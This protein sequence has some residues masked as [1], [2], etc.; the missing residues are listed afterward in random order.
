MA[1]LTH[2]SFV[3]F[4]GTVFFFDCSFPI[5]CRNRFLFLQYVVKSWIGHSQFKFQDFLHYINNMT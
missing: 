1:L 2:F 4:L 3:P 5:L